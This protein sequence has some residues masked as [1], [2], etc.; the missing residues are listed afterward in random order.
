MWSEQELKQ[1]NK[2]DLHISAPNA[3]GTMHVP[4][5]I[6]MVEVGGNLYCR[7]YNG[8]NGRWY[9]AAKQA[10]KGRAKFGSVD[11][12]VTFEFISDEA[13][14]KQIDEAYKTKYAGSPYLDGPLSDPMRGTTVKLIPEGE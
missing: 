5:W 12:A 3:D 2:E 13:L 6:W 10:G 9:M 1:A 11:R 14:D 4:T 7:S 8:K